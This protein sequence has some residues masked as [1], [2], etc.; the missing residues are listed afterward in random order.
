MATPDELRAAIAEGREALAA[1]LEAA[2]AGRGFGQAARADRRFLVHD[3]ADAGEEPRV[4]GGRVLDLVV[5]K[6]A[7]GTD[8]D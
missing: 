2:K 8:L 3:L 5:G 6:A 1:A 7:G 4:E